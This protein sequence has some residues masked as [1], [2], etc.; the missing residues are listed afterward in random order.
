MGKC[1]APECKGALA[2]YDAMLHIAKWH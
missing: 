2:V 1:N